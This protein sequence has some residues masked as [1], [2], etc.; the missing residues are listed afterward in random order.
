MK[1]KKFQAV[2]MPEALK[3]IKADLGP[4]A[5][6]LSTR[7]IKRGNGVFGMLSRPILE[8]TAA[9]D[10]E[11][12]PTAAPRQA[13]AAAQAATNRKPSP[14]GREHARETAPEPAPEHG[15]LLTM[16]AEIEGLREELM[17]LSR[18]PS[19]AQRANSSGELRELSEKLDRLLSHSTN[20]D[21]SSLT[22]AFKRIREHL[23][24]Q[25]MDQALIDRM[26]AFLQEKMENGALP[27]GSE[28]KGLAELIRRTVKTAG[29]LKPAEDRPR[30]VV[31]VGPTGVGKTT[32]TA[33]LAARFALQKNM[34][35]GVITVDTFRIGAVEQ[36]KTYAKIM[37]VPLKVA[38]DADAFRSAVN[39]FDDRELIFV[40]TGGQSPKDE[41]RLM[42][43]LSLFPDD[44]Q[45]EVHL[46]LSIT[47]RTR[48]LEK[49]MK[50][51][52]PVRASRLLLTKLDET[53]CFGPLFELPFAS[54]LPLS[55][56]TTGQNVP[57]DMDEAEPLL[58]AKYLLKGLE[59][60]S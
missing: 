52:Q 35:V 34:R 16:K 29:E 13:S 1:V 20:K 53:D 56:L 8:V 54:R 25:D 5:V 28:A 4:E 37:G 51:Y 45:K 57:D 32:T 44:V 10:V 14:S 26:I 41:D 47:T 9:S 58:V 23:C 43:L 27:P 39:D 50:H 6:I 42:E 49:I 2:D 12:P 36:I 38:L 18:R 24:G 59:P 17:L 46:V 30:V 22:P 40:D 21:Q 33:K 3:K 19:P 48:D 31:L 60:R 11:K 15:V 7:Q 55:F